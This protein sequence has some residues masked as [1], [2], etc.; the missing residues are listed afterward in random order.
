MELFAKIVNSF[1]LLPTFS[2]AWPYLFDQVPNLWKSTVSAQN[3]RRFARNYEKTVPFLKNFHIRKLG[4]ITVVYVV[5]AEKSYNRWM[6]LLKEVT[7][8]KVSKYGVICGPYFPAFGLNTEI[9][10]LRIQSRYRKIRTSIS[11][12]MVT[13]KVYR[14]FFAF[15]SQVICR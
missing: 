3:F 4:Q 9:Y 2:K 1:T 11:V 6:L 8:R 5:F 12:K 14:S 7:A 13:V 15:F 10:D